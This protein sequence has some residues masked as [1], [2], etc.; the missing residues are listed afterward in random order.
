MKNEL[1][2][3]NDEVKSIPFFHD[4]IIYLKYLEEQPI[5][6]TATGNI[7]LKDIHELSKRFKEQEVF[8]E[9]KHFGWKITTEPQIQF[10][11]QIKIIA[12]VMRLTC[13]NKSVLSITKSGRGFLK[14]LSSL[15][16]FNEMVLHYWYRVN[17]DYFTP[18]REIYGS[19]F[20]ERLQDVQKSIWHTLLNKGTNW[21]DYSEFCKSVNLYFNFTPYFEDY[22]YSTPEEELKSEIRHVLF[23]RNLVLFG[24]VEIE[25]KGKKWDAEIVQFHATQPGLYVFQKALYESYL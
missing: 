16:Q 3:T 2:V 10:L 9:F 4:F 12:R 25:E 18:T 14:N 24:C 6:L 5:K 1:V 17:W 23:R 20:S 15:E 21:I 22:P 11:H 8:E 19:S 7:S 13:K